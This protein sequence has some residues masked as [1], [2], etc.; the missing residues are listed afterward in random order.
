VKFFLFRW[1]QLFASLGLPPIYCLIQGIEELI[2][3]AEFYPEWSDSG[4]EGSR[5]GSTKKNRNTCVTN[6]LQ[7]V[8][9][10]LFSDFSRDLTFELIF[11]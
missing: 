7:L 9:V 4:R 5:Y 2:S 1:T 6:W 8:V 11:F 10:F 3:K